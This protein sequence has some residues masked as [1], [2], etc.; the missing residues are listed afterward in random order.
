MIAGLVILDAGL[1]ASLKLITHLHKAVDHVCALASYLLAHARCFTS[2]CTRPR[3]TD[4]CAHGSEQE[5]P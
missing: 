1:G 3:L 4:Q 5:H 2:L